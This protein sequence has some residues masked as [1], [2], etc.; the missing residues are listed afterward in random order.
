[1]ELSGT[2]FLKMSHGFTVLVPTILCLG[3]YGLSFFS[4]SRAL[5]S[6]NLAL[7]YATWSG[8]GILA[9]TLISWFFFGEKLTATG[10][11]AIFLIIAGC[12]LLNLFGAEK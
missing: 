7:A 10:I 4:F 9:T 5:T 6:L 2:T 1:M 8:V 12:I 3:S 11:F